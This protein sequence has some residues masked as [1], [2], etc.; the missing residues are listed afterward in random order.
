MH[1][2]IQGM[3]LKLGNQR[4]LDTYTND[5]SWTFNN[6]KLG[7]LYSLQEIPPFTYTEII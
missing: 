7:S 2:K 5:K 6:K 1:V 4:G 3:L